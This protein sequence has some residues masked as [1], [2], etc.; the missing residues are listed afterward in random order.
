MECQ[1]QNQPS[2]NVTIASI[3]AR[4]YHKHGQTLASAA[5]VKNSLSYWLDFH[6]EATLS[7]AGNISQQ[8]AFRRWLVDEKTLSL[9]SVRKVTMI[10]K[11]AFNWAYKRGEIQ[12]VPY[13]E[14]VKPPRPEPKGRHLD[15]SE[16][17][18]LLDTVEHEHLR[19]FLLLLI[20]TGARPAAILDLTFTQIDFQ[21]NLIDLNPKG[22]T[23]TQKKRPIVK[24]P[25]RLKPILLAAKQKSQCPYVVNF[26]GQPVKDVKT[27]WRKLRDTARL[28]AQV[29]PYS[30]RRTLAKWLR[31]KGVPAW[32]VA[33]QLGHSSTGYRIT[34]LYTAHSPDYLE[35]SVVA[36]DAL[37]E[38]IACE[39]RVN[40]MS[41]IYMDR[42]QS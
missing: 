41:S 6:G 18:L 25:L 34:E 35:R 9:S 29:L 36:I 42:K 37:Y 39:T 32:E 22:R 33:E 23:Q 11:S 26:N 12:S 17:A 1:R 16:M 24:L 13:F 10:G 5:D 7:E 28:D 19:M 2:D 27:S 21:Q 40:G 3:F 15:V 20:G 8:E 30:L 38:A 4:Y 14:L 31:M